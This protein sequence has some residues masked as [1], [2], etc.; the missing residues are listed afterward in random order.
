M[1]DDWKLIISIIVLWLVQTFLTIGPLRTQI[2]E[3]FILSLVPGLD[4]IVE[5]GNLPNLD[6]VG[7]LIYS[8]KILIILIKDALIVDLLA[9]I[10]R[11]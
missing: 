7:P 8:I 4:I 10:R 3:Q 2:E 9:K 11:K 5:L 6:E 1:D